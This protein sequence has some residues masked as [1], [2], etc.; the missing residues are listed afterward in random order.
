MPNQPG[1]DASWAEISQEVDFS[2][3]R[4]GSIR[5]V[6]VGITGKVSLG[7]DS[8]GPVSSEVGGTSVVGSG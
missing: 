3:R 2:E 1:E 4:I 6:P 5:A 8:G 7:L